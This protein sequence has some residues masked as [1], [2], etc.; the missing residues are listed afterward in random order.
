MSQDDAPLSGE[1]EMDET[2]VGG[3]PRESDRRRRAELG[4]TPQTDHWARKAVVF[5][6]VER[7]GRIRAEV[8]P[9]SRASTILPRA[10]QY[11]LPGSM[12]F[13][14]EYKAYERLGKKGYTH[15]RIKHH[16]R[17]YVDGDVHYTDHRRVLWP[18]QVGRP[19]RASRGL[20]QVA[21]GLP[22]RVG[23]AL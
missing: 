7:S 16:A 21:S 11:V 22:E 5:G 2:F 6:A 12:V 15:R 9:D 23:V 8:V 17:V 1:V 4:W 19:W 13:T 20:A 18:L 3:R 14:D 10:H